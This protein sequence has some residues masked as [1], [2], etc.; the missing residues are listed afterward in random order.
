MQDEGEALKMRFDAIK[1]EQK[2]SRAEFARRYKVPGGDA[3]IYQHIQGIK[4]ISLDAALA[5]AKGFGC[6]LADISQRLANEASKMTAHL[7]AS[8][9]LHGFLTNAEPGPDI[10]GRIPLISWVQAGAFCN[11]VDLFEPG[12]AEEWLPA[13]QS[14]GPH[15]YALRVKGDSMTAAHGL[16]YPEGVIVFVD[17]DAPV[18][19]GCRVIAKLPSS[20]AATFKVYAEDAGQRFL[21]PLNPQ[22][23]T[24]PM[25]PDMQLCG[26]VRGT[27]RPE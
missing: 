6:A 3:M 14:L 1:R 13:I 5:Y 16:S 11:A 12:D 10:R 4:P 21:K 7:A 27:Y 2:M 9:Q 20:D 8:P 24:I 18:T 19:N 26:V 25:T 23:P 15:A 17:P 22:Y